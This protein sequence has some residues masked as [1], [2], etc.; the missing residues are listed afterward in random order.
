MDKMFDVDSVR[1]LL[2]MPKSAAEIPTIVPEPKRNPPN[3]SSRSLK[4]D[5]LFG[6]GRAGE[7]GGQATADLGIQFGRAGLQL[8]LEIWSSV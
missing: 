2:G 5:W 3:T 4:H 1:E 7:I 8:F 6:R